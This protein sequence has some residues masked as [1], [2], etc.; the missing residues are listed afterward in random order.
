MKILFV[1]YDNES[2]RPCVPMGILY[3]ASYIKKHG[4]EDIHFYS[5]DIYHYSESHLTE[6]LS[7]NNFDI[8]G[9]GFVAGYFQ[10]KKILKIC[11][12]IN[13]A[14]NRPFVV[15]GGHGPSPLPE[16]YLKITGAD[17]VVIGEGEIPFLNLVKAIENNNSL[18]EVKS[19]AHRNGGEIIINTKEPSTKDIETFPYPLVEALPMEHYINPKEFMMENTDRK[20]YMI[21]GRGCNYTCNFCQRIEGGIRFRP[22]E[23]VIDEIKKYIR[24]YAITY[25]IFWDELFMI[26]KK[27]V[28]E[29]AEAI[30]KE[31]ININYWCTGRLNIVDGNLMK[32]MKRSG[33]SYI[34]YGI[35]QFDNNALQA[36]NKKLTEDQ[37]IKGIEITQKEDIYIDFNIIFGNIGDTRQS[38]K[39][40]LKLLKKYNDFGQLR[41]IRPVTPYPGS[42][43]YYIAIEKGLITGPE[44]FY[45]LHNNLELLTVNFTDIPDDEFYQ[46]MYDAN[47]E[48]IDDYYEHQKSEMIA[49]FKNIYFEKDF[50]FRGTRH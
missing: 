32:I 31:N 26:S 40:S 20:I 49:S 6:Y 38:L 35:E 12:A 50:D 25:I 7:K 9:I 42:P 5:Q 45:K 34:N 14:K 24:D 1:I 22:V 28:Y 21:T 30:L 10:H 46:L 16:F 48:I 18:K 3:I 29:I 19:I 36:M 17:A 44:D 41:V 13:K 47:K 39:K 2:S 27:R 33:C 4:Y 23:A 11:S 43:L 37:I 15:L 8:V